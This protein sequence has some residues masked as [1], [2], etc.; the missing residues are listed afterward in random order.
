MGAV[1]TL[2]MP[3]IL[4]MT[5]FFV[6]CLI[7][8]ILIR[9]IL[10]IFKSFGLVQ[11]S[12]REGYRFRYIAWIPF[13]SNYVIGRLAFNRKG[14]IAYFIASLLKTLSVICIFFVN[15]TIVFYISLVYIIIYFVFDMITINRI[16]AKRYK[17][18]DVFTIFTII[19]FG[20]LSSIFIYT[21]RIKK[22][23]KD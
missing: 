18:S 1:F 17:A 9:F 16:Y 22:I 14:G 12:K 11:L 19:T 13:V 6:F 4:A 7:C 15:N 23:T 3:I 5:I 2:F 10:Y 21:T 20:V 8:Y